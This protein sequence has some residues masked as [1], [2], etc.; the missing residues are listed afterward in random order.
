M[1]II[2]FRSRPP[3]RERL[4]ASCR[5]KMPERAPLSHRLCVLCYRYKR[6][7]YA[8]REFRSRVR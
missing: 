3:H 1:K 6:L 5:A 4:C 7:A 2:P 8:V